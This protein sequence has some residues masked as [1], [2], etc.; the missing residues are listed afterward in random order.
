MSKRMY[1]TEVI[2]KI[3]RETRMS[4]RDVTDALNGV[5]KVIQDTLKQGQT[6]TIPGFGTF[7][8]PSSDQVVSGFV[9][10]SLPFDLCC[11]QLNHHLGAG[12]AAQEQRLHLPQQGVEIR[13][14]LLTDDLARQPIVGAADERAG[15]VQIEVVAVEA[16]G[17]PL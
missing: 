6:V 7:Y 16:G 17:H 3:A 1:K 5:L 4:R 9:T 11:C 15:D 2:T 13:P 14:A 12:D 8:N 10:F